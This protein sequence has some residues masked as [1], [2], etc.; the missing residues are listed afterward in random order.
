MTLL[1]R[2]IR[3]PSGFRP[4]C[5]SP[6]R[7]QCR[8]LLPVFGPVPIQPPT[9]SRG[10]TAVSSCLL[11]NSRPKHPLWA[12]SRSRFLS[13][14]AGTGSFPLLTGSCSLFNPLGAIGVIRSFL[15]DYSVQ[16]GHGTENDG[17]IAT[18]ALCEKSREN[19]IC[20]GPGGG[21]G[22]LEDTFSR[23][24]PVWLFPARS[25]T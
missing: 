17:I 16:E 24:G 22:V 15:P 13:I 18:I 20:T 8:L 1:A 14:T 3:N 5:L 2:V 4:R 11:C 6:C 12:A 10:N 19:P 25:P 23:S 9:Y 7:E 21:K